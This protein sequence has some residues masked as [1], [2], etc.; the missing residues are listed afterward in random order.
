MSKYY[1]E[2]RKKNPDK[3]HKMK[4]A[5]QKKWRAKN[6]TKIRGYEEAYAKKH[7]E[8]VRS[9]RIRQTLARYGLTLE[10]YDAI[11]QSQG[12]VCAVCK[13]DRGTRRMA[14]DHDHKTNKVRGLLCQFCNT[15]LGKF[16][17]NVEILKRAIL[18]L[19]KN[20]TGG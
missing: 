4:N 5:L 19:E 16:L 10:Q 14:V 11:L 12:G 2:L 7:P 18:Y 3:I 9:K 1:K 13:M 8:K 15:A 20:S 17:D 6:R